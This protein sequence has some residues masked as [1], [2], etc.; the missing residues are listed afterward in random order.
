MRRF[1][2]AGTGSGC[3]KTTVTCGILAALKSRGLNVAAFKCGPDYID[4]MFHRRAIGVECHNLDSFFCDSQI[5]RALVNEYSADFSVI[6]GVMGFYDGGESSAHNVAE[7]TETPV[8]V[9]VDCRGMSD[10]IGA[11]M[12]GFLG[13]IKP[14]RIVGFIFDRLPDKLR[15][16]AEKLCDELETEFF[17][18][19]PRNSA[20]FESR[21]LGLVTAD[22]TADIAE[23]LRIL[24]DLAEK[25]IHIDKLLKLV[26]GEF[27]DRLEIL[28]VTV[29]SPVIAVA[30]DNAFCFLYSENIAIL[31]KMGCKIRYFSPISD[32]SVLDADGFIFC[33]GYPELYADQLSANKSMLES[34]RNAVKSGIP[35]IAECGGFMYLHN[36]LTTKNGQ[37]FQMVGAIDGNAFPTDKLERFGYITL[38]SRSDSLLCTEGGTMKAH[39]FHYWDSTACGGD[40]SAIKRDGRSWECCHA[41]DTL[42]AG[43]PHLYFPSDTKI[44]ERFVRKC[45]ERRK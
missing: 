44:V 19:M 26:G 15:P 42:Y 4:P 31:E 7:I 45:G 25:H 16:L 27:N 28:R 29:N 12:S 33:G 37:T 23:K 3:G 8:V 32:T 20:V 38:N 36:S 18:Y 43:F 1:M 21:H 34:V 39:E 17:G 41:S 40:F 22:E 6:E 13:Y 9:V 14:N 10:S 30:R 2:I 24:G 35:T 11:V 5:I